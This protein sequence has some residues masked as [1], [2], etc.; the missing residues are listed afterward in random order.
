MNK[1][2]PRIP[3]L[4][5]LLGALTL[6]A[7]LSTSAAPAADEPAKKLPSAKEVIARY[8]KVIGGRDAVLK[9]TSM[10]AIGKFEMPAQG[11]SGSLEIFATRPDKVLVKIDIT[12]FGKVLQGFDGKVGWTIDPAQGPMVLKDK[13]LEQIRTESD[14]YNTLHEE[15]NYTSMETVEVTKF[16]GKDCYKLKLVRKN[17]HETIEFYDLKTAL[18]NGSMSTQESV[19]GAQPV[20]SIVSE[21]REFGNVKMPT[22]I[23]QKIGPAEQVMTITSVENN[24]VADSEFALPAPIKALLNP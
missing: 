7:W 24:K 15:K 16:E 19:L 14:F 20:T 21:Y 3:S 18:L 13:Q 4:A 9:Q 12:G 5:R 1:P 11:V 6:T 22:R 23:Q 10:H 17:G 8:I 2:F